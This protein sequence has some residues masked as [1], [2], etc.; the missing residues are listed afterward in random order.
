ME[1]SIRITEGV[2]VHCNSS[3]G[4]IKVGKR[5]PQTS[6]RS[7]Q[8]SMSRTQ[9]RLLTLTW[10]A[11]GLTQALWQEL[12]LTLAHMKDAD[13]PQ[14]VCIQETHWTATVAAHFQSTGWE[15]YTPPTTDNKSAGLLTLVDKRLASECQIVYADPKPGR[16]Q[17]LRL[18]QGSWTADVINIYQKPYNSHPQAARQA[19]E[20][21]QDV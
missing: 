9:H 17:H 6:R 12:L 20:I 8:A 3:A 4:A 1:T 10:N 21:R 14:I 16:L 5:H 2:Y 15:V 13:R 18:I 11:G 7:L 19:R